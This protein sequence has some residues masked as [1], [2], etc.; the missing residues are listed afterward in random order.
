M[1]SRDQRNRK[2]PQALPLYAVGIAQCKYR[3]LA[4]CFDLENVHHLG[5]GAMTRRNPLKNG[6]PNFDLLCLIDEAARKIYPSG[7]M[8][9][10]TPLP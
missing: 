5:V 10:Q 2:R 6:K 9:I 7:W 8:I 1:N 3:K 4:L